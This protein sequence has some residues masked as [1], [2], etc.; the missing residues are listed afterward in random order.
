MPP[1]KP[2]PSGQR[3]TFKELRIEEYVLTQ[4]PFYLPQADE[5]ELF[6][7]A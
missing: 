6:E 4:E 5:I 3:P 7:A 2:R 1:S